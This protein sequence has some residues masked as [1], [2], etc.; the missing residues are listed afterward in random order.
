MSFRVSEN[1][2]GSLS[3]LY[4]SGKGAKLSNSLK[5]T[6]LTDLISDIITHLPPL[7]KRP[8]LLKVSANGLPWQSG[9]EAVRKSHEVA[10]LGSPPLTVRSG[11]C[12]RE[13]NT[14]R[15]LSRPE[16]RSCVT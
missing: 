16:L 6:T 3:A 4:I 2:A 15:K 8:A 12:G 9:S 13:S 1:V 5:T 7:D 14:E 11:L 10:V